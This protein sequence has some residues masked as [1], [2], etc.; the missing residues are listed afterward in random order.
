MI[1]ECY[2]IK[3]NYDDKIQ[4]ISSRLLFKLIMI[5]KIGYLKKKII[6]IKIFFF[7]KITKKYPYPF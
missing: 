5:I 3:K 4:K 1:L 6:F 7:F 2:F